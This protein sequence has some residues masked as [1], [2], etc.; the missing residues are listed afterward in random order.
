MDFIALDYSDFFSLPNDP[1]KLT[2]DD[3]CIIRLNIVPNNRH[4]QCPF[5]KLDIPLVSYLLFKNEVSV[6]F[7]ENIL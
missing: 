3:M 1:P 4:I 7:Q 5:C 6:S 2:N